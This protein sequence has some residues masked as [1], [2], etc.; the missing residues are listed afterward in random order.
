M[1][2]DLQ[3]ARSITSV[4]LA[5]TSYDLAPLSLTGVARACEPSTCEKLFNIELPA[6]LSGML[7]DESLEVQIEK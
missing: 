4:A 5:M 2:I 7:I 6:A 3:P 1:K